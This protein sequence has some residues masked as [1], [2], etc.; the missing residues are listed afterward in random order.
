MQT[1]LKEN[2]VVSHLHGFLISFHYCVVQIE[3][4]LQDQS[5]KGQISNIEALNI[6]LDS[7]VVLG[8]KIHVTLI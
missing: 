2:F 4:I 3:A 8:F 6:R 5:G 1:I 7:Q